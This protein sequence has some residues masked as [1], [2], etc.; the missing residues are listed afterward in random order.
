[1]SAIN[2][3]FC[4]LNSDRAEDVQEVLSYKEHFTDVVNSRPKIPF[5]GLAFISLGGK[6]IEFISLF[7]K[8]GRVAT[9]KDRVKFLKIIK[10]KQSVDFTRLKKES[11]RNLRKHFS[12]QSGEGI[13]RLTPKVFEFLLKNIKR[14]C[15]GNLTDI[16]R[17]ENEITKTKRMFSDSNAKI[18][19]AHEKDAINLSLR[20]AGFSEQ[21]IP[22]WEMSIK[23]APFLTGFTSALI[24][25]DAMVAHD[26]EV[27]GDWE[28]IQRHLV[29]A[30]KFKKDGHEITIMNV[31]RH[32]VEESLGVDLFLYHHTYDSYVMIQYKRML[33]EDKDDVYRPTDKSYKL[34][35]TRMHEFINLIGFARNN[36]KKPTAYRL[37]S[38]FFYF[39]LCPAKINDLSAAEMIR[40]MYLPLSYWEILAKSPSTTGP[41][42][43]KY[44]TY[45]NVGRH[46]NNTT[47]V[48][49]SQ[50][51]WIGSKVDDSKL[52]SR[53]ISD[54]I[55]SGK[56][57]ILA[58]YRKIALTNVE[59]DS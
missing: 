19:I 9:K 14:K 44:F 31:N 48:E 8:N 4:I 40:G 16:A 52:I 36:E 22:A 58:N 33:K 42:G 11:P 50:D 21:D 30:R 37:N 38:D 55:S 34:E 17:L 7:K 56:S 18:V 13:H 41:K 5:E 28:M 46:L 1:M 54:S 10:L 2:G 12:N 26:A 53:I 57:V 35:L 20:I 6:K 24:R 47:F 29:G 32:T 25:E 3:I 51:G 49:L 59:E 43:G 23:P 39:K 27:F 15:P 45:K